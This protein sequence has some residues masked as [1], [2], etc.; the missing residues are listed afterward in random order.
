MST[1]SVAAAREVGAPAA[2]V[3]G[4]IA[5]YREHHPRFLPPAFSG[6]TVEE[7]G[8][9]PGTVVR[10]TV[11]AGGRSRPYRMRVD[12]P[13]PGRVLRESDLGSSLVTTFTVTPEGD[14]SRVRI[15][16]TWSGAPGIGGFF[17]R[18]FAPGAIRRIYDDEL[19]R[20]D[21]YA[22]TQRAAGT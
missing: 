19:A 15:E 7:G 3:F 13:E 18:L 11:S 12:E 17:E 5:D 21:G 8:V 4:Y 1:V 9:G 22:R 20:L 16:T 14:R 6:F 10:F 2:A